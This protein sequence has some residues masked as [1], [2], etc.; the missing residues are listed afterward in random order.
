MKGPRGYNAFPAMD[1]S[2]RPRRVYVT[3]TNG[4]TT[5]TSMIA[6]IARASGERTARVTTL[7]S[8]LDDELVATEPTERA[9]LDLLEASAARGVSTLAVEA[10]S[11]ALAEGFAHR[12]PPDVGVFTNLTRD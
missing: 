5:T 8:Y 11:H 10:S 4:K 2:I 3:G 9:Y 1:P 7:G 6:A 12:Y